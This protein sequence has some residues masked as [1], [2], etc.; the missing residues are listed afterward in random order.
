M[1]AHLALLARRALQPAAIRPRAL[2]RFESEAQAAAGFEIHSAETEAPVAAQ[3]APPTREMPSV[4]MQAAPSP[5][6]DA[7]YA[8]PESR[9]PL[10]PLAPLLTAAMPEPNTSQGIPLVSAPAQTPAA[11]GSASDPALPAVPPL[12]E[13]IVERIE[14][15][16]IQPTAVLQAVAAAA[17]LPTDQTE[18]ATAVSTAHIE[19]HTE[20]LTLVE[21][22]LLNAGNSNLAVSAPQTEAAPGPSIEISI[23]RIE[24]LPERAVPAAA[25][26]AA[27]TAPKPAA[28]SLDDYLQTRSG[29]RA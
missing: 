27:A 9:L 23:G 5:A 14:A 16:P 19:H 22:R 10:P 4:A 7:A 25:N 13:R 15:V 3:P 17:P 8:P 28:Q 24:I 2:S 11:P 18:P 29:R 26:Q 6:L 21:P 20:R 1:S 12:I